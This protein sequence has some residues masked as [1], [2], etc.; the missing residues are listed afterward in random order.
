MARELL[1]QHVPVRQRRAVDDQDLVAAAEADPVGGAARLDGEHEQLG[2]QDA[3]LVVAAPG[4]VEHRDRD[5]DRGARLLD[6]DVRE[7][8][9]RV[10]AADVVEAQRRRP[11]AL[12]R[13]GELGPGRDGDAVDRGD[14][15]EG[16]EAGLRGR[17]RRIEHADLGQ[18]EARRHA[19]PADPLLAPQR[20]R[21]LDL[22]R[23][24]VALLGVGSAPDREAQRLAGRRRD[25]VIQLLPVADAA[26][27]RC[28][29][30]DRRAAGPPSPPGRSGQH[31]PD[32][33]RQQRALAGE[34]D[35]VDEQRQQQIE[36]R[37]R[38]R[39]PCSAARAAWPP[40]RAGDRSA[41]SVRPDP[42]RAGARSRRAGSPTAG[43]RSRRR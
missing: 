38:R 19:D 8:H 35:E 15:V 41:G 13:L 17:R 32:R 3:G 42:R 33:R 40:A 31:R 4:G 23:R 11:G 27:R 28:S 6:L 24:D 43:I 25:L 30:R 39:R 26:G 7:R 37:A 18:V 10:A 20:A 21:P 29:R 2:R 16:L 12:D 34:V 36:H 14:E 9:R 1:A 5:H 22:D